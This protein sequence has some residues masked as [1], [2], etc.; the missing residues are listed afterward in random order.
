[1]TTTTTT[2]D[3]TTAR[4]LAVSAQLLAGAPG[5]ADVEGI[6][7]VLRALRCLQLDPVNA[8]APS[9]LL[10][11]W[12]RLGD[13]RR[14]DLDELLWTSRWLFEY[15]AHAASIVL[16]EDYPLHAATMRRYPGPSRYGQRVREWLTANVGLREHILR[17]LAESWPLPST[18]FEDRA[19]VSW[20]S[21]GW[22]GGR[23]VERMLDHL[24][25]QGAVMVAGRTGRGRLWSPAERWLSDA[26][27]ARRLPDTDVVPLAV[28]HALRALGV[29]RPA[30]I[31]RHFTRDRYP[32]LETVLRELESAGRILPVLVE[33]SAEPS[34][35]HVDHL[36]LLDRLDDR[37]WRPRTVLLSPF[38][39]L[40]CDRERTARLWGFAFRNEMYQ[41]KDKREYGY[42][43]MPILHGER[44]I[45]RVA[46]RIE[47]KRRLLVIEGVFAEPEAPADET[48]RY[49]IRQAIEA[50]ARFGG[51]ADI[52]VAGPV[53][54]GWHD[55][56]AG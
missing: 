25:M 5:P 24:M 41:P 38:D 19:A 40:I 16:T 48:V 2:L 10:V 28:Q 14:A 8:V 53:P 49:G 44:L 32:G 12:S 20:Q 43:V 9:H 37:S 3:L 47:R 46:A 39:N 30:D 17:R 1:M 29:A 56:V 51:A 54:E 33:G 26:V 55:V 27:R 6:K 36:D 31:R 23:N 52:V 7:T 22:T 13:F 35:V 15:W 34:Y 11:L 4:R 18:A 45:G 42:Y 50:M 21:T